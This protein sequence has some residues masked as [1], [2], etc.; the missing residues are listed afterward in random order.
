[1]IRTTDDRRDLLKIAAARRRKSMNKMVNDW[2][3]DVIK[4]EGLT[5]GKGSKAA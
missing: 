4:E 1:M 3:D 2:I 5:T